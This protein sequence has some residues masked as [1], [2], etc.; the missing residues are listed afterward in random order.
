MAVTAGDSGRL[1]GGHVTGLLFTFAAAGV[2]GV[3]TNMWIK[4]Q[5]ANGNYPQILGVDASQFLPAAGLA[6]VF[7]LAPLGG[8]FT[9]ASVL[10]AGAALGVAVPPVWR[11]IQANRQSQIAAA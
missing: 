10:I 3:L 7:L 5:V 9:L 11:Q 4:G 1:I 2:A 8:L 6:S